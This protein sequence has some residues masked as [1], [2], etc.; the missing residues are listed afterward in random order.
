MEA[1]VI[2]KGMALMANNVITQSCN[3][4]EG[5]NKLVEMMLDMDAA[6]KSLQKLAKYDIETVIC[7]HGGIFDRG[8]NQRIQELAQF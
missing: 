2:S 1:K 6:K 4:K 7:Y 3:L 5:S 8:V